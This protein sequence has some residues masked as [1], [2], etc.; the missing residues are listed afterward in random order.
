MVRVTGATMIHVSTGT[1]LLRVTI[2]TGRLLSSA[3]AH[4]TSP[5][6]GVTLTKVPRQSSGRKTHPPTRPPRRFADALDTRERFAP[7]SPRDGSGR[8]VARDQAGPPRNDSQ[9]L[10]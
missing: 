8:Q 10:Q 7:R 6:V 4:Q 1:A 3:S 5:C 2:N 9:R